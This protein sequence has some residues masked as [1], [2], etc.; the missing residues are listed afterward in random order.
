MAV[1]ISEPLAPQNYAETACT[2]KVVI[3]RAAIADVDALLPQLYPSDAAEAAMLFKDTRRALRCAFAASLMRPRTALVDGDV[4]A[5]WG[6]CDHVL[7][8]TGE[9]WLLTARAAGRVPFAFLRIA[10]QELAAM[11]ALKSRLE[12]YVAADNAKALRLLEA[13]G[14]HLDLPVP[15]GPRRALFQ[16]FRI[17]A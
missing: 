5:M 4:A 11:L 16:R 13:L 10:R 12:G 17:E 1:S 9:P 2:A 3:R 6:V 14:F 8:D 15:F 7:H